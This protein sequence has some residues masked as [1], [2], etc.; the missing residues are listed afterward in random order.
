MMDYNPRLSHLKSYKPFLLHACPLQYQVVMPPSLILPQ[1]S[2]W[3]NHLHMT[4]PSNS[5]MHNLSSA[6][7]DLQKPVIPPNTQTSST[8]SFQEIETTTNEPIHENNHMDLDQDQVLSPTITIPPFAHH[9]TMTL[10]QEEPTDI[11]EII[12]EINNPD[13]WHDSG[14][15]KANSPSN[16][17]TMKISRTYQQ[18]PTHDNSQTNSLAC[19]LMELTSN[20]DPSKARRSPR[21]GSN[22][23]LVHMPLHYN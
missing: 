2:L 22:P 19:L 13:L 4:P 7:P 5:T 6:H 20:T 3:S 15:N 12:K 8:I 21:E 9:D 17:P 10:S 23:P 11:N 14:T 1:Q 18:D 16:S